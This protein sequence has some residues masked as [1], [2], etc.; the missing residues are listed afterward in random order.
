M[1]RLLALCMALGLSACVSTQMKALIGSPIQEAQI[2][3]GA[4]V[5]VMDMPGGL[6]AYQY[7]FGGGSVMIPSQAQSTGQTINGTTFVS[8]TATPTMFAETPGCILTFIAR[9][10]GDEWIISD[11]RVP[12]ALVC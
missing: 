4:P 11:I 7:R 2:Q 8:T 10:V 1:K 5:Q 3:Y 9:P 12:K 6:R